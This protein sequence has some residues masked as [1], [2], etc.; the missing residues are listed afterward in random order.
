MI[1]LQP[2]TNR[3][4]SIITSVSDDDLGLSTP[5]EALSVGDLIDH[6]N[7]FAVRLAAAGRK[8]VSGRRSPPPRPDRANLGQGWR[9]RVSH[10]LL[11][12]ALVWS[13]AEAWR[14]T[15]NAGGLELQAELVGL[16]VL[17]ELVVH[18]WDISVAIGRDYDAPVNEVEGAMRFVN[19]FGA[20]RD[21]KVFGPTVPVADGTAPLA[22]LLG[23]A[24]R[25][26]LWKPPR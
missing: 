16:L 15:S 23:L 17:D 20:P 11:E 24:G 5:C 21:G 18:A 13:D 26:P 6:V 1:D 4:I 7:T 14:G 2:A 9:Q 3:L 8:D 25:D 12:L 10:D 22:Q 19:A